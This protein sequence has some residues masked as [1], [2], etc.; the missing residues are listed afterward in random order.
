MNILINYYLNLFFQKYIS[1]GSFTHNKLDYNMI[2]CVTSSKIKSFSEMTFK[3]A[4][5]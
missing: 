1:N 3:Y 2:I 4:L 5:E